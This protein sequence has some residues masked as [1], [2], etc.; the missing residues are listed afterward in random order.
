[1]ALSSVSCR[2]P[3]NAQPTQFTIVRTRLGDDGRGNVFWA[4]T[5][6]VASQRAGDVGRC[7]G[8]SRSPAPD[9][10]GAVPTTPGARPIA[11]RMLAN[12]RRSMS[13]IRKLY[14]PAPLLWLFRGLTCLVHGDDDLRATLTA[15]RV[16]HGLARLFQRIGPVDCRPQPVGFDKFSEVRRD[17]R[18]A[19]DAT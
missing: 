9:C 11:V 13:A 15:H 1:M 7:V 10:A 2:A 4:G 14:G 5:D 19:S 17:L 8:R 6:D 3:P 18:G 12:S 16:T